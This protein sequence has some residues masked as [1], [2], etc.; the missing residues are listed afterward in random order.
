M[1]IRTDTEA[2]R[3]HLEI[4]WMEA[5]HLVH[6]LWTVEASYKK[7]CSEKENVRRMANA[8]RAASDLLQP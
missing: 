6:G 4:D 7:I 2:N 8:I 5:Q 1:N 3:V